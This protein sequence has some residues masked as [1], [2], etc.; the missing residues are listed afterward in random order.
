MR[1]VVKLFTE[2]IDFYMV[3]LLTR[4]RQ[5]CSPSLTGAR[6]ISNIHI[7]AIVINI[8][9]HRRLLVTMSGVHYNYFTRVKEGVSLRILTETLMKPIVEGF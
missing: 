2:Y 5:Y 9:R 4:S 8:G 7:P 1:L 3:A 6:A